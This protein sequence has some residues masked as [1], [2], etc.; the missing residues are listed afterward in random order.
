MN[1]EFYIKECIS[2]ARK[3]EEYG[4]IPVGALLLKNNKWQILYYKLF[5]S[6]IYI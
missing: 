2:L 4:E 5:N 3:S 6:N 1:H